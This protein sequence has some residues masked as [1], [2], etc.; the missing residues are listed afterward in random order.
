[1][2]VAILYP[3]DKPFALPDNLSESARNACLLQPFSGGRLVKLPA[4]CSHIAFVLSDFTAERDQLLY[5]KGYADGQGIALLFLDAK[6]ENLI[7]AQVLLSERLP[8]INDFSAWLEHEY[9]ANHAGDIRNAARDTLMEQGISCVEEGFFSAVSGG[10]AQIVALFLTAGFSPSLSDQKGIPVLS[11]AVRSQFP[12]VATLLLD[13]GADV[14]RQ[15]A[16]RG[17]SALMDAIQKGD[18]AMAELLL[19]RGATVDLRSKDGQ[20]ALI[21]CSG[22]GDFEGASLLVRHGADPN[23]TDTLGMSAQSY[24]RLFHNQKLLELFNNQRA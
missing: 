2:L 21:I 10:D 19:S 14:D 24:A 13:A 16:D 15:S 18:I 11:L 20:T 4:N 17:Y 7:D 9:S 5:C 22:R 23:A 12:K 1:M 6:S 8:V 3:E